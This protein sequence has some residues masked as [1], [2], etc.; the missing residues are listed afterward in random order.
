MACVPRCEIV[1]ELS[2]VLAG[3]ESSAGKPILVETVQLGQRSLREGPG[4]CV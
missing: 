4:E 1:Q 3:L 2:L